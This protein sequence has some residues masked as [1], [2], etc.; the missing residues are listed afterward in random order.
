MNFDI[1]RIHEIFCVPCASYSCERVSSGHIHETYRV[2]RENKPLYI[3]QKINTRIFKNPDLLMS[4]YLLVV[5]GLSAYHWPAGFELKIP[6][7]ISLLNGLTY[8]TD[9]QSGVWR[10]ITHIDGVDGT[11]VPRNERTSYQTGLAFGAFLKSVADINPASIQAVLPD[12]HS[13]AHRYAEF[14]GALSSDPVS[15]A[16]LIPQ[17]IEFTT[18]HLQAMKKI[19]GL[20]AAGVI[21]I[22]VVHNDTK[23]SNVI[24]SATG[25]AVGVID[26]D[27]IMPGS[28]LYDFGDAIR[29]SANPSAEDESDLSKVSFDIGLFTSFSQGYI[30]STE[31]LLHAVELELL[32][33]A[34][35]LITYIIGLRFLTDYLNGDVY[36]QTQFAEHNLVRAKVQ[37]RLLSLMESQLDEMHEAINQLI[38]YNTKILTA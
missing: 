16:K 3:L 13:L 15:R 5:S 6:Q 12:F 10:L 30:E 17:E 32:P 35:L 9:N 36:Y 7:L 26:L 14:S 18:S 19:P 8:F 24:F 23:Q 28:A 31:S 22:R 21:P 20:M 2:F 37:F 27:T 33:E 34:A 11:Q 29:T 1:E 25:K 38:K 4:N